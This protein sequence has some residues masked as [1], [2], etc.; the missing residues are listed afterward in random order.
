[1]MPG[2]IEKKITCMEIISSLWKSLQVLGIMAGSIDNLNKI[3]KN[4]VFS[5]YRAFLQMSIGLLKSRRASLNLDRFPNL[6]RFRNLNRFLEI[7]TDLS[8]S[9]APFRVLSERSLD[10]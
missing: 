2:F 5:K 4:V 9:V 3:T 6:D 10:G 8:V 7:S 1:M